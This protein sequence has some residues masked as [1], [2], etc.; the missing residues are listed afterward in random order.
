MTLSLFVHVSAG[1]EVQRLKGDK[2]SGAVLGRKSPHAF[3]RI[4]FSD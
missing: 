3:S 2:C 4:A 1:D